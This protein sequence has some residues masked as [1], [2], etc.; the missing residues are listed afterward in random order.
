MTAEAASE[1][2]RQRAGNIKYH[3]KRKTMKNR[4]C[5]AGGP[6]FFLPAGRGIKGKSCE[7]NI[8]KILISS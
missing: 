1:S 8:K 7:K 5:P 4:D 2:D 3:R 6:C